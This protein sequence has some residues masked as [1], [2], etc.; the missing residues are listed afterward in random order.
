MIANKKLLNGRFLPV[1]GQFYNFP[2]CTVKKIV[3]VFGAI[4][5]SFLTE[6]AECI[7]LP[8]QVTYG[9][10]TADCIGQDSTIFGRSA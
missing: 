9:Y 5:Y 3:Y 10:D 4:N 2:N 8:A 7:G 6:K 1:N